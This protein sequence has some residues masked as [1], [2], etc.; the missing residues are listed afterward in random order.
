[1]GATP[2]I[3]VQV[4]CIWADGCMLDN[5]ACVILFDLTTPP[6]MVGGGHGICIIV[7]V[8]NSVQL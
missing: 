7:T 1:M 2:N 3:K 8:F 6:L 5:C 4:P